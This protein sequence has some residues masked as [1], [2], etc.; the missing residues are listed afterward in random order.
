MTSVK[1][2]AVVG[3]NG[4]QILDICGP[5]QVFSSANDLAGK[6]LYKPVLANLDDDQV[7]SSCGLMINAQPIP[8]L[9]QIQVDTLMVVG[10]E[11]EGLARAYNN[12]SYLEN[13]RSLST[14]SKRIASVCTGTF[15]LA[16][17]G[18][19]EG[20]QVATHWEDC[21]ELQR[22]FPNLTVDQNALYV[23]DGNIWTSAGVTA[24]IDMS[25]ALVETD[26][27]KDIAMEVARRLVVYVRRPGNQSQF[28]NFLQGQSRG[29][30]T[31]SKTIDWMVDNLS[32]SITTPLMAEKAGMSERSFYRKFTKDIGDTPARYLEKIRLEA[33]RHLLVNEALPL[34]T[35][36]LE[37]GFKTPV[38]LIQVFARN[39][40]LTPTEY[41]KLHGESGRQQ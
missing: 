36:A 16:A 41:R 30:G 9:D 39:L 31:L 1:T 20:K 2:I 5:Y 7:H 27:G 14:Q 3:F 37:S 33:A 29:T 35:V 38:R 15:L 34:K 19:L 17:A 12:K 22:L 18:L 24:G 13:I 26:Y 6:A 21:K 23:N 28:S 4:A 25:L 32:D 10:G 8:S 40:G 11:S